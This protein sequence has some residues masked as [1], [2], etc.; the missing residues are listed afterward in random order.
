MV[1]FTDSP[2]G[3]E[4]GLCTQIPGITDLFKYDWRSL[5]L[6]MRKD[7]LRPAETI[8]A[9][10]TLSLCFLF[11][12][13]SKATVM[14]YFLGCAINCK[15]KAYYISMNVKVL[16]YLLLYN[17]HRKCLHLSLYEYTQYS[18]NVDSI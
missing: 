13:A 4:P 5:L 8:N 18:P 3:Q 12:E 9:P 14:R 11:D 7:L 2:S 15:Q 10:S 17:L 1:L 6:K 16:K